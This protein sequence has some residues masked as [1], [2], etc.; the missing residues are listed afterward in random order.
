MKVNYKL[1][2][3]LVVGIYI[4]TAVLT[5]LI[6]RYMGIKWEIVK[7]HKEKQLRTDG[8]YVVKKLNP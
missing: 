4:G 3:L 1:L 5:I 7:E 8:V 2:F 6:I